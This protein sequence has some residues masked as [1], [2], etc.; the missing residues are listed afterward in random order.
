MGAKLP[1]GSDVAKVAIG[2]GSTISRYDWVRPDPRRM[3][4]TAGHSPNEQWSPPILV[5]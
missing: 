3:L 2:S 1:F 4:D 5:G